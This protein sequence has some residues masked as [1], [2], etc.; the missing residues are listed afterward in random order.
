MSSVEKFN[1]FYADDC[2][3]QV[4]SPIVALQSE[5]DAV[6]GLAWIISSRGG[7]LYLKSTSVTH[8]GA[9]IGKLETSPVK[10]LRV[11]R[12]YAKEFPGVGSLTEIDESGCCP[13]LTFHCDK[14]FR[15]R[16][17]EQLKAHI[18]MKTDAAVSDH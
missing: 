12:K 6:E 11:S 9:K 4:G 3:V 2:A 5:V 1:V 16:L 10:F 8:L 15:R 14:K 13:V 17:V 7:C 18:R